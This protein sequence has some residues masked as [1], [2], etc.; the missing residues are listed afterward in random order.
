[1]VEIASHAIQVLLQIARISEQIQV[2]ELEG[3]RRQR[4]G[5][6]RVIAD[7]YAVSAQVP[8]HVTGTAHQRAV[9]GASP[10][11]DRFPV[12]RQEPAL[13]RITPRVDADVVGRAGGPALTPSFGRGRVSLEALA[14]EY[15]ID[16]PERARA[17]GELGEGKLG[18]PGDADGHRASLAI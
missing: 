4:S 6:V 12:H 1:M 8:N 16:V 17:R 2:G 13:L 18:A 5:E 10:S 9:S 7:R 11:V 15:E 3:G 14:L